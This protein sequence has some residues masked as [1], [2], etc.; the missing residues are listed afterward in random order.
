MLQTMVAWLH[1]YVDNAHI[2]KECDS[3]TVVR[4]HA[5]FYAVC[6]A[7]FYLINARHGD[8]VNCDRRESS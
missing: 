4:I 7:L 1:Q 3:H 6:Q 2:P 8:L 5:V